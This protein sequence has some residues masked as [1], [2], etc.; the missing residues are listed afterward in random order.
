MTAA[1]C[2]PCLFKASAL[3][4]SSL[5]QDTAGALGRVDSPRA[6]SLPPFPWSSQAQRKRGKASPKHCIRKAV[7]QPPGPAACSSPCLALTTVRNHLLYLFGA[8]LTLLPVP[9]PREY[10]LGENQKDVPGLVQGRHEEEAPLASA[11]WTTSLSMKGWPGQPL[12]KGRQGQEGRRTQA[13][14]GRLFPLSFSGP[15]GREAGLGAAAP[16]LGTWHATLPRTAPPCPLIRLPTDT[17]REG[18][19]GALHCPP[20]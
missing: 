8:C 19:E 5:G 3:H 20:G 2:W 17:G 18:F 11:G 4:W 13:C 12:L 15:R 6:G 10:K 7:P 14:A 1:T 9:C 16:G